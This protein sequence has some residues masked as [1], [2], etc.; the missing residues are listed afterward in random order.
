MERP[1][2]RS[3]IARGLC[4]GQAL[5]LALGQLLEVRDL[6]GREWSVISESIHAN[7]HV[8]AALQLLLESKGALGNP[9][10][11]VAPLDGRRSP[12]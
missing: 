5:G 2:D 12:A 9:L 3:P 6:D 7:H 4:R 11:E 1:R 10:L 8:L